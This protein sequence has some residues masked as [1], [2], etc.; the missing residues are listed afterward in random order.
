MLLGRQQ[1]IME[2]CRNWT[3]A[4]MLPESVTGPDERPSGSMVRSRDDR[5]ESSQDS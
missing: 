2:D 5:R 4:Q 1:L 3:S